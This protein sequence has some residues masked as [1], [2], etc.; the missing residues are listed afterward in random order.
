M[1]E[2]LRKIG[3]P[4]KD[5]EEQMLNV[6]A[7]AATQP[8]VPVR[9]SDNFEACK[10]EACKQVGSIENAQ[11]QPKIDRPRPLDENTQKQGIRDLKNFCEHLEPDDLLHKLILQL[12]ADTTVHLQ[13]NKERLHLERD[14]QKNEEGERMKAHDAHFAKMQTSMS[15]NKV[16]QSLTSFGLVASGIASLAI[17]A[18]SLGVGAIV[19]GG[20]LVADQ[21]LDNVAKTTVATWL[22][23]KDDEQKEVWLNRIHLF[24]ALTLTALSFGLKATK[25]VEIAMKVASTAV[26]ATKGIVDWRV[27]TH[28]ALVIELD[29]ACRMSQKDIEAQIRSMQQIIDAIHQYHENLHHIDSSRARLI[30]TVLRPI[31]T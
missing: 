14:W 6:H 2:N 18:T 20:L 24:C 27:N 21:L 25:A 30:S 7:I 10:F 19:V 11:T 5:E 28:K 26:T 22:A 9:F 4:T 13:V 31:E 3:K 1:L 23:R 12:A 8:F 29:A 15:W 17:G 16:S